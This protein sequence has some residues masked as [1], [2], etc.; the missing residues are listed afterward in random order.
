[1]TRVLLSANH[2]DLIS[3]DGIV[4][5]PRP[6]P[7]LESRALSVKN[8]GKPLAGEPHEWFDG[9]ELETEPR[10]DQGH[11]EKR[12][13]GKPCGQQRL[14]DLLPIRKPRQLPTS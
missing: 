11:G 13:H 14:R 8:V 6:F 5:P 7:S 3:L 12:P 10:S 4:V 1:M 2:L 9:R